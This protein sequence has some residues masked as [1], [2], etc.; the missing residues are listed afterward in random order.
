MRAPT[1]MKE[2]ALVFID[3]DNASW[4]SKEELYTLNFFAKKVA[5]AVGRVDY[6]SCPQFMYLQKLWLGK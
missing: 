1:E 3:P 5:E 4:K 2:R 6:V